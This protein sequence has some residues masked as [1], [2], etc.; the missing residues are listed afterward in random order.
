LGEEGRDEV[1]LH[2]QIA[3]DPTALGLGDI[4]IVAQEAPY[5][6]AGNLDILAAAEDIYYSIEI[7]L[8]EVDTSHGFRTLDIGR[9]IDGGIRRSRM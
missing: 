6:D 5:G 1:W 8:G 9:A 7:Q 4:E 2:E 3:V